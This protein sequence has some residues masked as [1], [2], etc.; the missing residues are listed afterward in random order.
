MRAKPL[1]PSDCSP[2][3]AATPGLGLYSRLN[4]YDLCA[5][6]VQLHLGHAFDELVELIS[7]HESI[8]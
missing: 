1:T 6:H 5:T 7:F 2:Q 3:F 8:S 4:A